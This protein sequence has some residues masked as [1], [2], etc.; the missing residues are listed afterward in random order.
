[1]IIITEVN[2]AVATTIS[3]YKAQNL[4]HRHYSKRIRA[5]THTRAFWL[6]KLKLNLHS[7]KRAADR[8]LRWMK[9]AARN[10][11]HGR[12]TVLGKEMFLCY[13]SMSLEKQQQTAQ[14]IASLYENRAQNPMG[15]LR[16]THDLIQQ[17]SNSKPQP[18]AA[19]AVHYYS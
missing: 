12:S 1:M 17:E 2:A 14:R 4:V 18:Q 19:F 3:I 8:D 16:P 11:K 5:R 9:S 13:I 6:Y 15:V 7:L 10:G